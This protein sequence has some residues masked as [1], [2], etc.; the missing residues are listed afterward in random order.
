[1]IYNTVHTN[2]GHLQ[3]QHRN[4]WPDRNLWKRVNQP[5]KIMANLN[6][7]PAIQ[8]VAPRV[9]APALVSAENRSFGAMIKGIQP[10][11]EAHISTLENGV[12]KGKFLERDDDQGALI[13]DMLAKNLGVVIGDEVVF[14]GQGADGSLAAGKLVVRGLFK[15]GIN[16]LDRTTIVAHLQMV[17]E[18]YSMVDSVSEIAI[19]L[20]HDKNRDKAS[21]LIDRFLQEHNH[22]ELVIRDWSTLMP[23]VEESMKIDWNTGL[24]LYFVLV[25]VVGFGIAN[26]FLMAFIERIHEFGVLLALG[27]RPITL[28]F[29]L[30]LESAL[31]IT[32]GI[33][34]GLAVGIAIVCYFNHAGINFG[35]ESEEIMAQ[36][37]MSPV[38]YPEISWLVIN[39]SVGI[40]L[41]VALLLAIYPALKVRRLNP[42][43]ALHHA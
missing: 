4:Y 32:I 24:I 36:Y 27:M 30:Y 19:L 14:I 2:T 15:T 34:G 33:A 35:A 29:M 28:S 3:I 20:D 31:L 25:M 16:E 5:G 11:L 41:G 42:V 13:G 8:A 10:D 17:Q 6:H 37:G 7:V 26:T 39:W 38:I 9:Q 1:M 43:Q 12:V 18:A 21:E 40:V 23:G 22:K